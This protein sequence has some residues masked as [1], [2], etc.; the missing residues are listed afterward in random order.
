MMFR[1][2]L[3]FGFLIAIALTFLFKPSLPWLFIGL[4]T[5]TA[6]LPDID[7][8]KSTYG[9]RLK[10]I[11]IPISIIF[12]HRGFFHS[13]FPPLFLFFGFSYFNLS[14]IG[15]A[16]LVGYLA[17]LIGDAMTKE[18]INFLHPFS[19]FHIRGPMRTGA[20]LEAFLFYIILSLDLIYAL[21]L[22]GI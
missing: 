5:V 2:H 12:K 17:H 14:Y 3:A 11:S 19:T 9:R 18:G 7:H 22:A 6:A 21:K 1:T 15:I 13:I 4:V 20:I 10:F 8:P 16:I